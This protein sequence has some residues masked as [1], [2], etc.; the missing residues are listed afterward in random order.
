MA[1]ESVTGE[2]YRDWIAREIVAAAGL[3]ETTPD[4]P[5]PRGTPFAR[6]HTGRL[7]AGRPLVIP[8]DFDTRAICPAGG[9]VSTAA[10]LARFFWQLRGERAMLRP[11][12]RDPHSSIERYYG[13]GIMSGALRGWRWYGHSGGLQGYI[14]RTVVLPRHELAISVLTNSIVGLAHP[15]VDGAMDIFR[16]MKTRSGRHWRGRWW[17]VWGAVDVVPVRGRL[18]LA[19]PA[20]FNPFLDAAEIRGRRVALAG[21]FANHGERVRLGRNELW[22]GG[23]RYLREAAA[24]REIMARYR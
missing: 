23:T 10:D 13:L 9:F 12:W 6:G 15:W 21:G 5:L 24:A 22:L 11:R 2:R 7:P 8:G 17:T 18:L 3:E 4:M 1:I 14:T 16:T 19:T 20:F